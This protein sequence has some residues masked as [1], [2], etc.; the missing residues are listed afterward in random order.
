MK[1]KRDRTSFEIGTRLSMLRKEHGWSQ[2]EFKEEFSEFMG[3]KKELSISV[4]SAWEQNH[5]APN[6]TSIINLAQFYNVSVDFLFGITDKRTDNG[7][8]EKRE[9]AKERALYADTPIK[10]TDYAKY[11][12]QP[13]FVKFNNNQHVNQWGIMNANN[14]TL[15]CRDFIVS[16]SPYITIYP[17]ASMAPV[18]TQ[19][20]S[21]QQLLDT[22]YV[23]VEMIG[24]DPVAA[25]RYN[26][27]Y[28]H[29]KEHGYL[30]KMTDNTLLSYSGFQVSYFAFRG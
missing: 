13:V 1:E 20:S 15:V 28:I 23:W 18:R 21:F 3:L 30:V 26:G 5:R 9:Y 22:K 29:D 25:E 17:Y 12:G 27:R 14:G 24:K 10:K 4:V 19:I 8:D 7:A 2:K 6:L 16:F 11:N